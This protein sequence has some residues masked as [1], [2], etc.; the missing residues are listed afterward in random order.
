M[1]L[2]R[3]GKRIRYGAHAAACEPPGANVAI[4]VTHD[5]MQQDIGRTGRIDT[6]SSTD[7]PRACHGCAD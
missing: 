4:D 3:T 1:F 7:D 6:E 5:V 2:K